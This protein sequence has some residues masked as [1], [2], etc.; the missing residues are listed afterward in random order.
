MAYLPAQVKSCFFL[1]H[2]D[3]EATAP[4][5]IN[6]Q[7]YADLLQLWRRQLLGRPMWAS[8]IAKARLKDYDGVSQALVEMLE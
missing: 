2:G 6:K 4:C 5:V 8:I 3:T 1:R 7:R